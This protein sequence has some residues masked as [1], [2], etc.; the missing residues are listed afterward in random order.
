MGGTDLDA[1]DI[2]GVFGKD[3]VVVDFR[4]IGGSATHIKGDKVV[5]GK[6]EEVGELL[7]EVAAGC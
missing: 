2:I 6:V 4:D 7:V 1:L 3:L 5:E